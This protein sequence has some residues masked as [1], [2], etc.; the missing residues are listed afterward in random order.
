MGIKTNS[1]ALLILSIFLQSFSFLFIKMSTMQNDLKIHLFLLLAFVFMGL[2]AIVWQFLLKLRELS[3]VYP[4][5]SLVQ[6]I[7]LIYAVVL[8]KETV[9][10]YNVIG[11]FIMLVGIF[12]ISKA[13]EN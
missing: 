8:F 3:F 5:A 2:R 10:I 11:L 6:I 13:R 1:L 7:I 12:Y 4:F 9:T